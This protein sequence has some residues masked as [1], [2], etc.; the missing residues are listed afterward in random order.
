MDVTCLDE[1]DVVLSAGQL[2]DLS[3]SPLQVSDLMAQTLHV[4]L[5]VGECWPLVGGDQFGHLLVHPLNGAQHISKHLLTILQGLLSWALHRK[6]RHTN[7][8]TGCHTGLTSTLRGAV[9][10]TWR[11]AVFVGSWSIFAFSL[12]WL[13]GFFICV[14]DSVGTNLEWIHCLFQFLHLLQSIMNLLL[15]LS[16]CGAQSLLR[17]KQQTVLIVMRTIQQVY[18]SNWLNYLIKC[19]VSKFKCYT[20]WYIIQLKVGKNACADNRSYLELLQLF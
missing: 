15:N 4:A 11:N 12:E 5:S 8:S 16:L 3:V 10:T 20:L 19:F 2:S 14:M 13:V 6:H 1:V 18:N 7:K 9:I 17:G